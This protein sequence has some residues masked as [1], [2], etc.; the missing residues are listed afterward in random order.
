[1]R[2]ALA[3][4]CVLHGIAHWVGFVVAFQLADLEEAPYGTTLLGGRFDVGDTGIRVMGV[5]WLVAGLA[6]MVSAVGAWGHR[7]WWP[8]LTI[9]LAAFS[10]LLCL[11]GWPDSRIGVL[12]NVALLL[13]LTFAVRQGWLGAGPT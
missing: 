2:L 9:G 11:L 12:V 1:M 3:L 13:L 7:E 4:L 8:S 6:F 5:L 10:L